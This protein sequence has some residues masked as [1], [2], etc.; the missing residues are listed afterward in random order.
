MSEESNQNEHEQDAEQPP[1]ALEDVNT[2]RVER[3]FDISPSD[4][5]TTSAFLEDFFDELEAE[6]RSM[7]G[8][9]ENADEEENEAAGEE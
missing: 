6:L 7:L 5:E 1:E 2:E 3:E 9:G 4:Y 8:Q